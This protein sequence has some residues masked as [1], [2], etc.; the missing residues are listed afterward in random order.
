MLRLRPTLHP[1]VRADQQQL[2]APA[3]ALSPPEDVPV[4]IP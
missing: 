1:V 4:P 2:Y 3:E